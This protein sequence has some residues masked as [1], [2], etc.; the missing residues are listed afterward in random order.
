[1]WW[2]DGEP[3]VLAYGLKHTGG[4]TDLRGN[5]TY[6]AYNQN[7]SFDRYLSKAEFDNIENVYMEFV[8]EN[9]SIVPAE[10]VAALRKHKLNKLKKK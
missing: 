9:L 2:F 8:Q 3:T 1:M 6:R 5:M 7:N 4:S 10:H